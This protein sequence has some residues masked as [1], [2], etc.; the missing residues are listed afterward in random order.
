M[1]AAGEAASTTQ[2]PPNE[3]PATARVYACPVSATSVWF[4]FAGRLP[5]PVARAC[6]DEGTNAVT[7]RD[8]VYLSLD[9]FAAVLEGKT[10]LTAQARGIRLVA[11]G[12]EWEFANGGDRLKLPGGKR[13][14]AAAA[15]PGSGR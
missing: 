15:D 14:P 5:V 12:K 8:V 13:L 6:T 3:S 1:Y 11:G 4:W 7:Y 2:P 9:K 10:S